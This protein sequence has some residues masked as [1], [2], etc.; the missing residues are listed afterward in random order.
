VSKGEV[1][2]V[3]GAGAFVRFG[4]DLG[5]VYEGFLPARRLRGERFDLNESETALVGRRSGTAIRLGDPLRVAVD[6]IE[7][8]RGRVD[9]RPDAEAPDDGRAPPRRRPAPRRPR[10]TRRGH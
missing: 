4:G 2:G 7:S 1:S 3:V 8:A 9:L 5:D 6:D 10:E